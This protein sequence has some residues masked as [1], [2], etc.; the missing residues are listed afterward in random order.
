MSVSVSV[1]VLVF[2]VQLDGL[3]L[4]KSNSLSLIVD[5][6]TSLMMCLLVCV[7]VCDVSFDIIILVKYR[8][9]TTISRRKTS[10][11]GG[12]IRL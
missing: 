7:L 4:T 8:R 6:E 9:Y 5:D 1:L 2:A 12:D 3:S 10:K 11:Q